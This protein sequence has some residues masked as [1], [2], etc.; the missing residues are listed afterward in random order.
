MVYYN[1]GNVGFGNNLYVNAGS[2]TTY[3]TTAPASMLYQDTSGQFR[4][5][6]AASGTAGTTAT[7]T[8]AMTLDTSGNLGIGT[9]S[10]NTKLT[11]NSNNTDGIS[12]RNA[13]TNYSSISMGMATGS[14]YAYIQTT[15][16]GTGTQQPLAFFVGSS[17]RMRIDTSGNFLVGMTTYGV[18]TAGVS[19][20]PTTSSSFYVAGGT[21]LTIGRGTSDGVA[22]QFNRSGTN[23][24]N[25]SVTTTTTAYNSGSDYRLKNTIAPMVGALAKVSALKPVTYKWNI[26]DS[27]GEGFI[28]HELAE[29]CPHAV[30][31]AKDAVDEE[32]NPV[33]Q[34]IDTS[35]LVA[36]L[37]AAIQEQ[38][39][40]ISSQAAVITSLTER[41]TALEAK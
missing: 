33:Y 18:T 7:L 26:D 15:A 41:I 28:A 36:T 32:G 39:A 16:S 20:S 1:G 12:I 24:G 4:F 21:A 3:I 22:V 11:I 2:N 25:I 8:Q 9:T 40:Q 6:Q 34:G 14:S 37:T 27:D 13:D 35:F 29:V 17:E 30:T 5:Y 31:G 19:L 38:Q 10:P 23:C